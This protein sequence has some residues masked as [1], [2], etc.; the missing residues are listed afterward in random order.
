[1]KLAQLCL[2]T[3]AL[4]AAALTLMG[5]FQIAEAATTRLI[6]LTDDNSLIYFNPDDPSS[7]RTLSVTG[8]NGSLL[9]IDVRPANGLLYGITDT[10]EIYTIDLKTGAA[11]LQSTLSPLSYAGG[12]TSGFDFNPA[13]DRL[14]LEGVNDQ[15]FRINVDT[16]EIADFDP[17]TPGVQP[18]GALSYADGD[19]NVGADPNVTA[20]A[21]TNS[22]LGAPAGRST[23]LY[24]IDSELDILALQNPANAGG[25]STIGSLGI[26]FETLGGFDVLSPEVGVNTAYAASGSMLY[27]IDLTTGEATS[28]GMIGGNSSSLV[29]LAATEV[30]EPGIMSGLIGFGLLGISQLRKRVQL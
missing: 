24:T 15:N 28:L 10:N 27:G 20:V 18:D 3:P 16:G 30:P 13:A 17:D 6:G 19:V 11:S 12:Q 2:V 22:F 4:T 7:T 9:G 1:M 23:A 26:D 8:V 5:N 14:R 29:G 25:L 21:Y